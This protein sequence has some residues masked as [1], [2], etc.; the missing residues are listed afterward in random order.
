MTSMDISADLLEKHGQTLMNEWMQ[1]LTDF[2]ERTSKIPG[3]QT[4]DK[5]KG[6]DFTK[7]NLS[8]GALGITGSSW[9]RSFWMITIFIVSYLPATGSWP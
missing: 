8:M 9:I 5:I 1:N 4:M 2:Y 7:I 6:L 3:V